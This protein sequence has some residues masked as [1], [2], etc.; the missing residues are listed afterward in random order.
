MALHSHTF[1]MNKI[2]G[3]QEVENVKPV[4]R[5]TQAEMLRKI[6]GRYDFD[7]VPNPDYHQTIE[8]QDGRAYYLDGSIVPKADIPD[9]I[10]KFMGIKQV[11]KPSALE[12]GVRMTLRGVEVEAIARGLLEKYPKRTRKWADEKANEMLAA[13]EKKEFAHATA[14]R[15]Q[16]SAEA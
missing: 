1:R 16:E 6:R 8:V 7:S 14:R 4:A 15:T 12:G 10:K 9:Y 3:S 13:Q 2:T 11:A 5:F